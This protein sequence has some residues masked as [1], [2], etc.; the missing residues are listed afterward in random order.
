MNLKSI[1]ISIFVFASTLI[2]GGLANAGTAIDGKEYK[3][4]IPVT[5]KNYTDAEAEFNFLKWKKK[6]AMNKL[7]HLTQLTPAGVM[8]TIRMN[9][10]TLYSA[11]LVDATNGFTVHMPDQGIFASVL[12][13]DQKGYAQDYIW[14]RGTHKVTIDTK[15]GDFVWI[16]FRIGL[17]EGIEKALEAQK[18]VAISD[19]GS[20]VWTPK[21]YD[22]NQYQALHDKYMLEA[23]DSGMFLQYGYDASR[24][25]NRTKR[26]SDAAGWGGMDFGINN[27]QISKNMSGDNCYSTTFEDPLVD[28]FWSITLYDADGWLLPVNEKNVLNSREAVANKDGTYTVRFN[29]GK[30][31]VNN[32]QTKE[33][34]FGFAWR[35]YGS[36]YKVKAGQW[37]PINSLVKE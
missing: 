19:M 22:L 37:N 7:F 33:K 9:R 15:N 12:V 8:P 29:C 18:T 26:L 2:F 30:D 16:L 23:I 27:Y 17:E 32:L 14:R 3:N 20:K 4:T 1:T 10:D 36:S 35:T 31:A 24:I 28:E 34:V 21:N 6:D 25:D 5:E 13:L 11:A